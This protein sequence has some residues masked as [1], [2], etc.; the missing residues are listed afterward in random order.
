MTK[1]IILPDSVDLLLNEFLME[2]FTTNQDLNHKAI[3]PTL[4]HLNLANYRVKDIK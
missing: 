3:E 4:K 2:P 1:T